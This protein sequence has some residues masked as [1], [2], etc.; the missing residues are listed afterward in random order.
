LVDDM[1]LTEFA[2]FIISIIILSKASHTVIKS[3]VKIARITKL[4]ELVVGFLFLSLAT[5]IPESTISTTAIM[6]GNFGIAIGNI[7]GSNITV[8]L[9]VAGIMGLFRP[10]NMTERTL[11]KLIQMLFLCSLILL[12]L[13]ALTYLSK[14]VGLA[15]LILFLIFNLY[16]VKKK[17]TFGDIRLEEPLKLIPRLKISTVL[18]K[19]I[20]FFVIGMSIILVSSHFAV[21]S[22]S[23]I[24][25]EL[26]IDQSFIGATIMSVCASLPELSVAMRA[27]KEGHLRLSL[28]NI[29]GSSLTR[30][31]LVLGLVL[32]VSPIS[33]NIH[34]F[35]TLILFVF[36]STLLLG[37]FLGS[38]GRRKLD[39]MEGVIL[40]ISYFVFLFLMSVF[41]YSTV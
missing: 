25:S 10:V 31:T 26:N 11:N 30:L 14:V 13:V 15:L 40:I 4:G 3:S 32:L 9:L 37:F 18:L 2:I 39:R 23:T 41:S 21:N 6:S 5:V 27:Q 1:L 33:I 36:L 19:S 34:L 35:T 28:G 17:I 38:L 16:S 12:V 29:M 22:A 8:L 20:L 24:A 7:L